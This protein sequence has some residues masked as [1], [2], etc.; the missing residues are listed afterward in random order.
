M[1]SLFNEI[2]EQFNPGENLPAVLVGIVILCNLLGRLIPDDKEG[3]VGM[4]RKIFKTVGLY[5]SNRLVGKVSVDQAACV[6]LDKVRVDAASGTIATKAEASRTKRA[7]TK[8]G[9]KTSSLGIFLAAGLSLLLMG[10]VSPSQTIRNVTQRV[11][12]NVDVA[13][14]IVDQLKESERRE[15]LLLVLDFM[16][17]HCPT[18][19]GVLVLTDPDVAVIAPRN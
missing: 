11:C 10:C 15:T 19:L 17:E 18:I 12:Q 6:A 13:T 16:H 8:A 3:W 9:N 4:L 2:L 14:V 1:E 5:A 7:A